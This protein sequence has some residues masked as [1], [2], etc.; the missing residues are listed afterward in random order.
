MHCEGKEL[1]QVIGWHAATRSTPQRFAV[2]LQRDF[3]PGCVLDLCR[4]RR[5]MPAA[6]RR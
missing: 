4:I 5:Q 6:Q 3:T 1:P 2:M